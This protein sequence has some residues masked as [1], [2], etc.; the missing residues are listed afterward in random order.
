MRPAKRPTSERSSCDQLP[1]LAGEVAPPSRYL[2]GLGIDS[3]SLLFP[4]PLAS[5]S[6][7]GYTPVK[8]ISVCSPF[9]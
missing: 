6:G 5:V 1:E 9:A 7:G 2:I 4:G 8:S 3:I